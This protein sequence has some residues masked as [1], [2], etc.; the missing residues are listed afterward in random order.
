MTNMGLMLF[1]HYAQLSSP[2]IPVTFRI[3]H[4]HEAALHSQFRSR[5]G[6]DILRIENVSLTNSATHT[7]VKPHESRRTIYP[8]FP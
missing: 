4:T 2:A 1:C 5:G 3:R 7:E 8:A 6:L